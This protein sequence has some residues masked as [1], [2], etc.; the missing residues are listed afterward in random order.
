MN[1]INISIQGWAELDAAW[2]KA[3]DIVREELT[4]A[5]W[6]AEM[7]LERETKE[8]TPVG[9]GAAGGLRGSIHAQEPEV[10]ADSVIGITGTSLSYAQAVELGSRPHWAPI[11]PLID[12]V[13]HRL[14]ISGEEAEAVA[15]K[16]QFGIAHH[17][18]PAIGMFHR[19]YNANQAQVATMFGEARNRIA[20]RLAGA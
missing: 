14:G 20:A 6:Q 16:V 18:T 9:I 8:L 10:L 7:L 11:Q 15:R 17:G 5:M 12:W 19:A 4:A 13:Q 3:P 2:Q 1:T